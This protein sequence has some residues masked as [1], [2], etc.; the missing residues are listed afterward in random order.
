M[1]FL[2]SKE[3]GNKKSLFYILSA[4]LFGVCVYF[5]YPTITLF[6]YNTGVTVSVPFWSLESYVSDRLVSFLIN[7]DDK[8]IL[9]EKNKYLMTQIVSLKNAALEGDLIREENRELKTLLGRDNS[10]K[11]VISVL[12]QK[13]DEAIMLAYILS[14]PVTPPY[15]SLVLDL[16]SDAGIEE[17]DIVIGVD[18]SVMGEI[19]EMSSKTS[20]VR[21]LSAYGLK[22]SVFLGENKTMIEIVGIGGGNFY[23][24]MPREFSVR[25]S[26]VAIYP[27]YNF[28]KVAIVNS[29]EGKEGE[30]FKNIFLNTPFNIKETRSV[31]II[32]KAE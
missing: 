8:Q 24:A 31:G 14:G 3:R 6:L 17:G 4:I 26:D 16:G 21:L 7:F 27:G 18:G 28:R 12:E 9:S 5:W 22:T 23:I 13:P 19:V 25:E 20:K 10:T 15:D 1:K 29:I 2:P 30:M 11:T 32:K